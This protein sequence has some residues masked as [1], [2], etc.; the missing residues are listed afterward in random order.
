[1]L[2]AYLETDLAVGAVIAL[3]ERESHH[4]ARVL[5]AEPGSVIEVLNGRGDVAQ[6]EVLTVS[7]KGDMSIRVLST[8][9]QPELP[10]RL[11][12]MQAIP[13]GKNMEW[14]LEKATELGAY[15]IVPLM[16]ERTV[17]HLDQADA[18]GK[19]ERWKATAVDAIKQCGSPWLPRLEAPVS[20]ALA[21]RNA[22]KTDLAV[23]GSF[24]PDAKPARAWCSQSSDHLGRFPRDVTV[25]I[26]PEGDF[27]PA[28]ILALREAGVLPMTM[29]PL[30]LRVETAAIYA[31]SVLGAEALNAP[32]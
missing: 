25:W 23:F 24:E 15:R 19:M 8:S 5:R 9:H 29:G 17:V 21:L 26:G 27:S 7:R 22:P 16:T 11:T 3:P 4:L 10:C 12:L 30:V 1:M 32:R 20:F 2:R 6:T 18:A 14:I 31:L 28:E 13:K